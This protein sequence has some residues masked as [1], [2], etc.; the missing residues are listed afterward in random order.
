MGHFLPINYRGVPFNGR[1]R[2]DTCG[3]R[4]RLDFMRAVV[5][6]VR[7]SKLVIDNELYSSIDNGLL[8]LLGVTHG[9][10]EN[11]AKVLAEKISKLRIFEDENEKMNLSVQ[12]VGGS[13]HIV[14]Q[15]TLYADSHHGNR[16]S[17]INAAEPTRANELYEYFVKYC[18]ENIGINVATGSFGASMQVSF[19]NCGPV[20]IILDCVEGKIL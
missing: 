3:Q 19:T 4:G 18:K 2:G 16:P 9:D 20:T 15:F 17:F 14:S 7:D 10:T 6:R 1:P 8:I 12:D 5:Q 11:D 13:L